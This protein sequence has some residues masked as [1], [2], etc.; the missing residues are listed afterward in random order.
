MLEKLFGFRKRARGV[1]RARKKK[2]C[3]IEDEEEKTG[4]RW[5]TESV[6]KV[7]WR[8][9]GVA[10]LAALA[11]ASTNQGISWH[12][13]GAPALNVELFSAQKIVGD[14]GKRLQQTVGG[15]ANC[16]QKRPNFGHA[17]EC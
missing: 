11:L 1:G 9:R 4:R 12:L 15:A 17:V 8:R 2:G 10:G 3:V 14:A 7:A 16:S 5:W 13:T 6:G